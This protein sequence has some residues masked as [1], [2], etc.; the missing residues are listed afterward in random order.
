MRCTSP[1]CITNSEGIKGR[2]FEPQPNS[3]DIAAKWCPE[4]IKLYNQMMFYSN[5]TADMVRGIYQEYIDT[6]LPSE[7]KLILEQF[8]R[9]IMTK[10]NQEL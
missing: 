8:A 1:I 5:Q 3:T 4:C 10:L 6:D 7:V 9:E 2:E